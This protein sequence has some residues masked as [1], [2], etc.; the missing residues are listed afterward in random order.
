[1]YV[2]LT[3]VS[4]VPVLV[5][6]QVFNLAFV[7]GDALRTEGEQ[8]ATAYAQVPA[9]RGA[10]LD[11]NGRTLAANVE[12]FDIALDP[13][14]AGFSAR[15]QDFYSRLSRVTNRTVSQV[16]RT[17]RSRTSPRYV[18]VARNIVLD[19]RDR[20]SISTIPGV[21]IER[22]VSRRYNYGK[23][24]SHILGH[25]DADR[26]GIAGIE[27]SYNDYLKGTPGRRVLRR[28][29]KRRLK[30]TAG[31]AG[32]PP[33]HGESVVLTLDLARQAIMEEELRAGAVDAGADWATAVAMDPRTG[34]ILG[35][36]NFPTFDPNNAAGFPI[37][38]RRNHAI[39]D[40]IEPG[41][42]F[43]LISAVAAVESGLISMSDTVDTGDGTLVQFG[44]TL[45]DTHP[46]GRIPFWEVLSLSSNVGVAK[47]VEGMRPATLYQYARNL[48]FGIPTGI[49]LPGEVPGRLKRPSRWSGP[50]KSA[51]SRGYEIEVTPIQILA[52]YSSL[53][54]H[55]LLVRPHLVAERR[56]VTGHTVWMAAQDS[57]RRAFLPVTARTLMPAF[58]EVVE[59]GTA[60]EAAI[61]GVRI[62]GKT[63]TARI[64]ENGRYIGKY[65]ATFVGFF[66]SE[67]PTVALL[68]LM[69]RPA[70]SI[71]GGV[72]AAP[73]FRRIATRWLATMPGANNV[74]RDDSRIRLSESSVPGVVGLPVAVATRQLR[75]AGLEAFSSGSSDTRRRVIAQSDGGK[76][77]VSTGEV[78]ELKVASDDEMGTMPD[79]VGLGVRDA[80]FILSDRGIKSRIEGNGSV[81]KQWPGAGEPIGTTA[82][83]QCR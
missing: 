12:R 52:A 37:S 73:V 9:L 77:R 54:N 81:Y 22:R 53:A 27:Q 41:S 15:S 50:T 72:V 61:E 3:L 36:A 43:K 51:M 70:K 34:A 47:V 11:R 1:M 21:K 5:V 69:D 55:G 2:M 59:S 67:H 66:P 7:T 74:S 38:S 8:Q 16:R 40:Q 49:D 35:M 10:I 76:L 75:A 56:D 44:R 57:V 42:S 62:A 63:G 64:V 20:E 23:V 17:I 18:L 24:A 58:E 6:L 28:D 65:R 13:T 32:Q 39:S 71:Y 45:R 26:N 29:M 68:V 80:N 79:V 33:V 82:V 78:I 60:R 25:V 83:L 30:E 46:H 48:G 31:G 4:I 14:T 19:D